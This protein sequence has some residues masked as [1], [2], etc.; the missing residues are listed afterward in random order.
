VYFSLE[1]SLSG[2]GCLNDTSR[3]CQSTQDPNPGLGWMGQSGVLGQSGCL[4][5]YRMVSVSTSPNQHVCVCVC[6][7]QTFTANSIRRIP[8][9]TAKGSLPLNPVL[10]RC[11]AT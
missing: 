2:L 8:G 11:K 6:V 3:H 7:C 4:W 5:A 9:F 10:A 1:P